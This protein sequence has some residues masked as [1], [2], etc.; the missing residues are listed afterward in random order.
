MQL[1]MVLGPEQF[2]RF[3]NDDTRPGL[4]DGYRIRTFR[5]GEAHAYLALAR[6]GG[7]NWDEKAL[8]ET[9]KS[10][11]PGGLFFVEHMPTG[12]LVAT[13]VAGHGAAP[14]HPEGGELGWVVV[15]PV[16]RGKR[17]G[18]VVCDAV[19]RRFVEAGYRDIFL[20]TD[21]FRLPAIKTYLNLGFRPI[22][23]AP[24]MPERWLTLY[25]HFGLD[26][27]KLTDD[28]VELIPDRD[29]DERYRPWKPRGK[30]VETG[31]SESPK[32]KIGVLPLYLALYDEL[33]P[34]M[35]ASLAKFKDR[36]VETLGGCVDS[37]DIEL[38]EAPIT[39]LR[40]DA[41]RV[42]ELFGNGRVDLLVTLHLAYSPS[43][44]VA[45][46]LSRIGVPILVL[47]TTPARTFELENDSYLTQNHGVHGVMD[48][49]S[50]LTSRGTPYRVVAGHI[51]D[52]AYRTRI[53]AQ[54]TGAVMAKR[55]K[56]QRIGVTGAP[57]A[58]MGDFEI[59]ADRLSREFGIDAISIA[60]EVVAEI[61]GDVDASE[62]DRM[63]AVDRKHFS[64]D[65]VSAE[66][67]EGEVRSYLAIRRL[68]HERGLSG[69]TMNFQH[70][71]P[72]L[73]PPFYAVSRLMAEGIGYAGESD[74]IT[75]AFGRAA[76]LLPGRS[77]F[78]EI[79]CVDWDADQIMFSHMGEISPA[80][81]GPGNARLVEKQA[82][83]HERASLYFRFAV[84]AMSVTLVNIGVNSGVP[85]RIV[86]APLE[87]IERDLAPGVE[88]PHFFARPSGKVSDF[89]ES[90]AAAG[91]G[92]HVYLVEGDVRTEIETMCGHLGI[93]HVEAG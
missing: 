26:E 43:L 18:L 72:A 38:I 61:A 10:T 65:G 27:Q 78:S 88:A 79:F 6:L 74:I 89:L 21:D 71:G 58:G 82:L 49:T 73:P 5:Q 53:A 92:H 86:T 16:H 37:N 75:A 30:L 56:D 32:L 3:R 48:L 84:E 64:C 55:F 45:D 41:D 24:E 62:V 22:M 8:K 33:R 85:V 42:A 70:T 87:L 36:V 23:H 69:Y 63:I 68:C 4:P 46:L 19:V 54:L 83:G 2:D 9:L 11:I 13:T 93:P 25:R 7:F 47:D 52:E 57:F 31:P 77:M 20:H 66:V 1:Q 50:V 60:P 29:A 35:R 81:A 17:L 12:E 34:D 91:G 28:A 90:Y 67:H 59:R 40:S 39:T 76:D 44:L 15:D 51:D 14:D 80:F